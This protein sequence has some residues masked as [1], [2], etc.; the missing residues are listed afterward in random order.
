MTRASAQTQTPGEE[1]AAAHIDDLNA[2]AWELRRSDTKRSLLLGDEA[3]RAA[4]TAAYERGRAYSLLV[5]GYGAMRAAD[6]HGALD[7]L[8][9]ALTSF[10]HLGD[11]EGGRRA[12]NTL[13]IVYGQSG[14]YAD[15]LRTF[16]TLQILC[17]ELGEPEGVAEALNNTGAAYFHLGDY[18]NALEYHLQ[19]LAAFSTLQ[20]AASQAAGKVQALVNIGMVYFERGR[21]EQALEAFNRAETDSD[22]EDGYTRALLFNHLGRTHLELGQYE[23]AL[24]RNEES[25]NLM[26]A[27]EDL[28]GASYTRDDLAAIYTRLGQFGAAE[29]HL[30]GSL[31][32]KRAAGDTKGEA[33][34]CLQLGRLYLN[35]G[36]VEAAL[37]TLHESLAS[38]QTSNAKLEV[39]KAHRAL[40]EA[41]KKNRQFREAC[42]HLE[43]HA[44]LGKEMFDRDS[45]LRLQGLRVRYEVEQTEREKE[46][47]RLKNVELAQAVTALHELTASLQRANDDK[48]LLLKRLERLTHE[49]A[50]TGLYN[51][52]YAD[53]K[54]EQEFARA[55]RY[56]KPLSVAVCDID[57]FKQVNDD[58]SHQIG[59]AVLKQVS[60][61]LRDGVR[62]SDT[63]ARYGGEEFVVVLPETLPHHA[64]RVFERIRAAVANHAWHRIQPGLSVTVSIGISGDL[65]VASFDKLVGLADKKLYE[66]K[67]N[68]RN[69]V[70]V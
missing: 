50:L 65:S 28:L 37:D 47:Y 8:Q 44:Q 25:L 57:Y 35:Q 38:A 30:L 56:G 58:Y 19:A 20:D 32:T 45:D 1:R 55:R 26:N 12:L 51:R 23:Q 33:E 53:S 29:S 69:Q 67:H 48:A 42:L 34:A 40:A 11:K 63:A 5:L 18:A 46:L 15:A 10:E 52:R 62:Q 59:D 9:T 14:N 21:F 27:L 3:L 17:T 70:R 60:E 16:L 7:K 13:G 2:L 43:K 4:K 22:P 41:Y 64:A 6:L 68:G 61:L 49:D 54:L 31:K 36:R 39:H 66:A 24:A